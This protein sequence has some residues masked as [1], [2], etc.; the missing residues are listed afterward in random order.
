M[1]AQ[2]ERKNRDRD[3]ERALRKQRH[4]E[5]SKAKQKDRA[6]GQPKTEEQ[7]RMAKE[8]RV[9]KLVGEVVVKNMSRHSKEMGHEIFK[10]HAKEVC[11]VSCPNKEFLV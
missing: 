11:P 1:A 6:N 8:K 4:K 9:L 2:P 5:K 10:K 3:K 7:L